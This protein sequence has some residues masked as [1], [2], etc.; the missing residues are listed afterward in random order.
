MTIQGTMYPVE[1]MLPI[2]DPFILVAHHTD[3]YPEGNLNMGPK[4]R[5]ENWVMGDDMRSNRGYKMYYGTT[6][7]GFPAHPHRG[8]ETI[9]YA[10]TGMIDHFDSLGNSGRY[11]DGDVQWMTSGRGMQHAE[12]FPLLKTDATNP[13]EIVQIWFNLPKKFKMVDPIYKMIWN[14]T[15]PVIN[16]RDG[17]GKVKLII[18]RY[19]D[20]TASP[21][22]DKSWAA[23][24]N[25][26]V[27]IWEVN[28]K[29]GGTFTIPMIPDN[30]P[31]QLYVMQGSIKVD[32]YEVK[33]AHMLKY[34]SKDETKFKALS[35]ST[36]MVFIGR[37]IGEP[38]A[39]FG[40]F[41]MNTDSEIRQAYRDFQQ[42]EFGGWP[43]PK[44]DPSI[45]RELGRF[46]KFD[47][48]TRTEYPPTK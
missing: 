26:Y 48:G 8:F 24:P 12:M 34:T 3:A 30:I 11:G 33:E 13:F 37:P 6:V 22:N 16:T 36:I 35:D 10:R 19:G 47:D 31:V 18:G 45:D 39:A 17:L 20:V 27:N 23:D 21:I 7:P 5:P 38:V 43:W 28:L 1:F 40:P 46:S 15:I 2:E 4:T 42:T 9:T 32:K 25:N 44:S 29:E 14:E 41:V